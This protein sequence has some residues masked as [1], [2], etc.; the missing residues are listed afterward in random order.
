VATGPEQVL[1]TAG[2][3]QAISLLVSTLVRRGDRVVVEHPT[4]PNA[5]DVATAA[6]ARP[7]PVPVGPAGVDVALLLATVRATSPALVYLVPDHHNPTGTVLPP[8]ERDRLR[9]GLARTGTPMVVDEV[10]AELHLDG[11]PVPSLVGAGTDRSAIAIGSASKSFW[12]GL[13]V[14]WVRADRAL[15]ATLATQRARADLGGALLDQLVVTRLLQM[16]TVL[17]ERRRAELRVRRDRLVRA[18]ADQLPAWTACVP[19]GGLSLWV[20]LGAPVSGA[21]A[22]RGPAHGVHLVPGTAFGV[23]GSFD[24]HLRLTFAEPEEVLDEAVRRIAAT[25]SALDRPAGTPAP[26]WSTVV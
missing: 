16:R 21:L 1:V 8:A 20:D 14:G 2:A 22:R 25:W 6:G 4:Y 17:L 15:V 3:Q 18:L 12:S 11:G 13:R 10:F 23:D 9:A 19:T 26:R 24:D 5:I 7:V